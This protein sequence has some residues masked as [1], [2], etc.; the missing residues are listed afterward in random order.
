MGYAFHHPCTLATAHE[1]VSFLSMP[2]TLLFAVASH[3]SMHDAQNAGQ[4]RGA[5]GAGWSL[6]LD[7]AGAVQPL[8]R[9]P[10]RI[11]LVRLARQS[12]PHAAARGW[13][14]QHRHYFRA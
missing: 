3:V 12:L 8:P 2:K 6:S 5:V 11:I 4:G 1:V 10:G 7:L 9:L 14:Q 13:Q